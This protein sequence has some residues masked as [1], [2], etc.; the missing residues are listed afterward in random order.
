MSTRRITFSVGE[1][2]HIYNRG[3]DKRVIFMDD[4]D[5]KRFIKLL[6][7][8]NGS[9]PFVFRDFPIGVPYVDINRGEPVLA[10]G[11]YCLMP[12]HFHIL[13]KEI[14]ENGISKVIGKALTSYSS[15]FNKKYKR[16]GV[17]FEGTFKATHVNSD[18]YLKYLFAYIHLNPVKIIDPEWKENGI[19][20]RE[21]AKK[22]LT[23]YTYSS[24]LDYMGAERVEGKILNKAAFPEYFSE[25]KDFE[26]FIDEWLSFKELK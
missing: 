5:R 16:A 25:F 14:N 19:K 18:E 15:Y 2:Y 22:Y 24:Y 20:D 10:I 12:N 21:P 1:Y 9:K 7:V 6:F 26:Q 4:S 23:E 13:V 17:L 3:T 8:A 11:A